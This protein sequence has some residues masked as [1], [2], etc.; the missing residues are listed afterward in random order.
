MF[1]RWSLTGLKLSPQRVRM[2]VALLWV[3]MFG[4]LFI[5]LYALVG[6]LSKET[7][8]LER[9]LI[10]KAERMQA[11]ADNEL[12]KKVEVMQTM[13]TSPMFQ[14]K[15]DELLYYWSHEV[16]KAVGGLNFILLRDSR[17]AMN[18]L[19]PPG[20]PLP[21]VLQP[22]GQ[23]HFDKL[24]SGQSTLEFAFVEGP[25]A[26]RWVL[27]IYVKVPDPDGQKDTKEVLALNL[28]PSEMQRNLVRLNLEPNQI[29][30]L[31]DSTTRVIMHTQDNAEYMGKEL[32]DD[33]ADVVRGN[34]SYGL[35]HG[36][37]LTGLSI[38]AAYARLPLTGWVSRVSM[39]ESDFYRPARNAKL[40]IWASLL[41]IVLAG[42]L[43]IYIG[44]ILERSILGLKEVAEQFGRGE[45]IDF[46][47]GPVQEVNEVSGFFATAASR[48]QTI[49]NELNHRVK[50]T[51]TK[52]QALFQRT[53]QEIKRKHGTTPA[54][55]DLHAKVISQI[56]TLAG[57]H[58]LLSKTDFAAAQLQEVFAA[59]CYPL[60]QNQVVLTGPPVLLDA[61]MAENFGLVV[62]ELLTNAVKYGALKHTKGVVRVT[63]R[64]VGPALR[65]VWV[66]RDGPLLEDAIMHQ[67]FG[68][69]LVN[70]IVVGYMRGVLEPFI[71]R[72]GLTVVITVPLPR[73]TPA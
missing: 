13:V 30:L 65:L 73:S 24:V 55:E 19:I 52:V 39:S 69:V 58:N 28:E 70:R 20:Q 31:I 32:A 62:H 17:Q 49:L 7:E 2:Y 72:E 35:W 54:L 9:G 26:K 48:R 27:V 10:T 38:V 51:L 14:N 66:E 64:L 71:E 44:Y 23:K 41:F 50:N 43:Q 29:G 45:K 12:Y 5:A 1:K 4:A 53:W 68:T 36:R 6:Q 16:V 67:G 42:V 25:V 18:S 47:L 40:V 15:R 37:G 57:V 61:Q 46:V 34:S 60:Y 22:E 21:Q 56:I 59:E 33:F 63:W 8:E 11:I 3:T